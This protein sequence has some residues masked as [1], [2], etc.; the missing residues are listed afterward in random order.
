[1]NGKVDVAEAA[2]DTVMPSAVQ[3]VSAASRKRRRVGAAGRVMR[4]LLWK[5]FRACGCVGLFVRVSD[6]AESFPR[7]IGAPPVAVESAF[8]AGLA[9]R[10]PRCAS[11]PH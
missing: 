6:V 11:G 8:Q 2:S 4:N 1:M 10:A 9:K 7:A 3:P 5:P